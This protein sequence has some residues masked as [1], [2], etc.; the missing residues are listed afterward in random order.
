MIRSGLSSVIFYPYI[1]QSCRLE[2][3]LKLGS[4]KVDSIVSLISQEF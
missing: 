4:G 3:K 2:L 1:F